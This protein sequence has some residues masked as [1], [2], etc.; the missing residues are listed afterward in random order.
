MTRRIREIDY[1]KIEIQITQFFSPGLVESG[2]RIEILASN[3]SKQWI[4]RIHET[5][6]D[7]KLKTLEFR[8][9]KKKIY[10]PIP[11]RTDNGNILHLFKNGNNCESSLL[12]ITK[13]HRLY[14]LLVEMKSTLKSLSVYHDL[15]KKVIGSA[16]LILT[17]LR[18]L[19]IDYG[20]EYGG[21][22]LH[23]TKM[24]LKM[25]HATIVG[26]DIIKYEAELVHNTRPTKE[27]IRVPLPWGK[28][29]KVFIKTIETKSSSYSTDLMRII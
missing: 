5:S 3:H 10:Q 24:I 12:V 22:C 9:P 11:I 7:A 4:I 18:F 26:G 16:I 27:Y 14:I 15:E 20:G 29:F 2:N 21:L 13:D 23:I 28:E 6:P 25:T 8:V 17:I 19:E 1:S